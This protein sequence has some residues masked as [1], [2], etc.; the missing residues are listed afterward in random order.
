LRQTQN[1]S[2]VPALLVTHDLE[3]CFELADSVCLMERGRLLQAGPREA[4]FDRPA[5]VEVARMLGVYNIVPAEIAA[6][7]P[8][9][10]MSRLAVFDHFLEAAYVPGHLIGD[11]GSVCFKEHDV[12]VR[13]VKTGSAQNQLPL[14]V[15]KATST[16]RGVCIHFEH[17]V[18][19]VI[20]DI[21][22]KD[23]RGNDSLWVE[24]PA[25]AIHFIG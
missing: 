12:R 2:G 16:A 3:E 19:A 13:S 7:D 1:R 24:I 10:K 14:R 6:L 15:R 17:D 25:A 5:T 21:E 18:R 8:G 20:S 4:V 11:R 23:L 9:R 22:W